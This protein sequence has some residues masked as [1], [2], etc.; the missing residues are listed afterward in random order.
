MA[1]K[2]VFKSGEREGGAAR[3]RDAW[4]WGDNDL[5][6][7]PVLF[8]YLNRSTV[9]WYLGRRRLS[10]A[11]LLFFPPSPFSP[12]HHPSLSP[13]V[14]TF[15][16]SV[17]LFLHL[18]MFPIRHPFLSSFLS[19]WAAG[20]VGIWTR[21]FINVLHPA[22]AHHHTPIYWFGF[23]QASRRRRLRM[24]TCQK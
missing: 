8:Y 24:K 18:P 20:V 19:L 22:P 11:S 15:S 5:F 1:L 13:P 14:L 7:A 3:R 23:R 10:S 21:L 4:R 12:L 6:R 2:Q 16:S 9:M 17:H